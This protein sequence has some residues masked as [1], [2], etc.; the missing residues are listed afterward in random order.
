MSVMV[1]ARSRLAMMD[2]DVDVMVASVVVCEKFS[3]C[4]L[5]SLLQMSRGTIA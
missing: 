5:M 2:F 1:V 4:D 3:I